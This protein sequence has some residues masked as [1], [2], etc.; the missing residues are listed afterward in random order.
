MRGRLGYAALAA[1]VFVAGLTLTWAILFFVIGRDVPNGPEL[2]QNL[3]SPATRRLG[4]ELEEALAAAARL[5]EGQGREAKG[6]LA[7][8]A[9]PAC[10][11]TWKSVRFFEEEARRAMG[12]V[13]RLETRMNEAPGPGDAAAEEGRLAGQLA[14]AQETAGVSV[15]AYRHFLG[16]FEQCRLDAG[17]GGSGQSVPAAFS[18]RADEPLL[19]TALARVTALAGAIEKEADACNHLSCPVLDCKPARA[20]MDDLAVAEEALVALANGAPISAKYTPHPAENRLQTL[21]VSRALGKLEEPFKTLARGPEDPQAWVQAQAEVGGVASGLSEFI[22]EAEESDEGDTVWRLRAVVLSLSRAQRFMQVAAEDQ[23]ARSLS[24]KALADAML[25]GGRLAASLHVRDAAPAPQKTG[26][27]ICAAADLLAALHAVKAARAGYRL[28]WERSTCKA[29]EPDEIKEAEEAKRPIRTP[30][31][32]L[33]ALVR[34]LEL[35]PRRSLAAGVRPAPAPQLSLQREEYKEGEVIRVDPDFGP[36][37]CLAD[38]GYLSLNAPSAPDTEQKYALSDAPGGALLFAPEEPGEHELGAYA[39]LEHGGGL[40]A[41]RRFEV[42]PLPDTCEGFTGLWQTDVGELHLIE[43]DG[44]VTGSYRR[45][46]GMR[47]GFVIGEVEGSRFEGTWISEIA[48][49]DAEFVLDEEGQS[50]T[51]RWSLEHDAR[52]G[53]VWNGACALPREE[54]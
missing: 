30:A 32:A 45:E 25:N 22:R 36:G 18:C 13:R 1:G 48:R 51:G 44:A 17:C 29:P 33:E 7:G 39:S 38:G 34:G 24:L 9:C 3:G 42:T 10:T 37:M 11:G 54:N 5:R 23:T 4:A 47:P 43:R 16:A 50:F 53:G 46:A 41:A 52:A 20:M 19:R 27:G 21:D 49:G 6:E 2:Q 31:A 26:D 35:D 14:A 15:L 40:L 28:C 8:G 12:Q